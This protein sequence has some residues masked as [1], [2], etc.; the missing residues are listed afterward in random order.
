MTAI[1][2]A[3]YLDIC[4]LNGSSINGYVPTKS[5][6]HVLIQSMVGPFYYCENHNI[7]HEVAIWDLQI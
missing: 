4:G 2:G 6:E 1:E 3:Q 5:S 7:T